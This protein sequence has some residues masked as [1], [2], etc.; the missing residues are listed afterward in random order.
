MVLTHNMSSSPSLADLGIP[1]SNNTVTVKLLNS[2]DTKV[3]PGILPIPCAPLLFPVLPGREILDADFYAFLIEHPSHLGDN[4]SPRRVM[5]D[6]GIRRDPGNL[7]P[8]VGNLPIFKDLTLPDDIPSQLE[9]GGVELKSIEDVIWRCA[10]L[11]LRL[12]R[13][14]KPKIAIPIS[15]TLVRSTNL[16][17]K[18]G[19]C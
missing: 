2:Y 15:I 18:I 3:H 1:S 16:L 8:A 10:L 9:R 12:S 7:V 14:P 6:L 4:Q 19:L 13:G 17:T 5:F 11:S